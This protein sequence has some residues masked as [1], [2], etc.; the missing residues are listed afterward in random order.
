MV[1]SISWEDWSRLVIFKLQVQPIS[2][3]CEINF[4]KQKTERDCDGMGE[5]RLHHM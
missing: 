2:Q 4:V 5:V 1:S 3:D